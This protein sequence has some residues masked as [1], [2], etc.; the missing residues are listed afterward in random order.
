MAHRVDRCSAK[1]ASQLT[2]LAPP[3]PPPRR[4]APLAPCSSDGPGRNRWHAPDDLRRAPPVRALCRGSQLRGHQITYP[5]PQRR[6]LSTTIAH[7]YFTP[8]SAGVIAPAVQLEKLAVC[9]H[10]VRQ[11][12]LLRSSYPLSASS[13]DLD[14]R[15]VGH[16]A[17]R[18]RLQDP[19]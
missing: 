11:Q 1:D 17:P 7:A 14:G 19:E 4:V 13:C 3:P 5:V 18:F 12:A 8:T 2:A 10:Y 9:S 16:G 15:R 6:K